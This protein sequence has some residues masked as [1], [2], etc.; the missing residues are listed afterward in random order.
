MAGWRSAGEIIG[1]L[2]D[3]IQS[4]TSVKS[5]HTSVGGPKMRGDCV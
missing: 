1:P 2:G 3:F 4:K 5:Y